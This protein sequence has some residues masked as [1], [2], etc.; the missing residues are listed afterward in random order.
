MFIRFRKLLD[1]SNNA[2]FLLLKPAKNSW[3][4][5]L[6]ASYCPKAPQTQIKT[7]IITTTNNLINNNV[8]KKKSGLL[9]SYGKS[10]NLIT[11]T[12]LIGFLIFLIIGGI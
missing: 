10:N 7:T 1:Q 4:I 8:C 2:G 11:V 9:D 12:G 6:L 5:S 3:F